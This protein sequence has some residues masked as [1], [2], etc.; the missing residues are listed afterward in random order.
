MNFSEIHAEVIRKTKRPDKVDEINI[1]INKAVSFLT[2]KGDFRRDL[3]EG[4]L[5]IDAT[6]YGDTVSISSFTRF[7]KFQ[8]LKP[9]GVR[10][11]LTPIAPEKIFTPKDQVQPN[12]YYVAGTSLTYTLSALAP[13]LEYGYLQYAQ[14]LDSITNNTHWMFDIMP[15]AI[16]DLASARVFASIGDDAS[17][18]RHEKMGMDFFIAVRQDVSVED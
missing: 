18:I 11:Y 4:T 15:Y 10:Y 8:F 16:I 9:T 7:R 5:N 2:L 17:A 6:L 14:V 3:V 12:R 13:S 1:A